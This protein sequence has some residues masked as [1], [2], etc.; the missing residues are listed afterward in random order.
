MVS[1]D[2]LKYGDF[3]RQI[4]LCI[5]IHDMDTK[6]EQMASGHKD[7]NRAQ[8]HTK[9]RP[10]CGTNKEAKIVNLGHFTCPCLHLTFFTCASF[11]GNFAIP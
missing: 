10:V 7:E 3:M 1:S 5:V 11:C 8:T 2:F 4:L 9:D 6:H